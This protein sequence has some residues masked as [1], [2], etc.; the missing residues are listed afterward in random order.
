MKIIK[1]NITEKEKK[2]IKN[3]AI[4]N[5]LTDNDEKKK[6]KVQKINWK[7]NGNNLLTKL[8]FYKETLKV[9]L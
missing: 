5:L 1:T 4:K 6:G 3:A 7:K 2:K 8:S 9:I